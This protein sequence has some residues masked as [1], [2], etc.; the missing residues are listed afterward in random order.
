MRILMISQFYPPIVGGEESMVYHLSQA[1]PAADTMS[2]SRPSETLPR[3]TRMA[4]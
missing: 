2:R 1:S 3:S 4:M